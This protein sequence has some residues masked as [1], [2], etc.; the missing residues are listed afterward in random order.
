MFILSVWLLICLNKLWLNNSIEIKFLVFGRSHW[1][2]W[3][4]NS[5]LNCISPSYASY[6]IL[7]GWSK[8]FSF[9]LKEDVSWRTQLRQQYGASCSALLTAFLSQWS[10]GWK[11]KSRRQHQQSWN[12]MTAGMRKKRI[13]RSNHSSYSN[14]R[15]IMKCSVWRCLTG[16][17]WKCSFE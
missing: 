15:M 5:Q 17:I 6:S 10:V 4:S 12:P 13:T 3:A 16:E 9:F 8:Y 2:Y 7:H 1:L 14:Q 11:V